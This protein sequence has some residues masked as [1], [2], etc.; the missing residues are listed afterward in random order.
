QVL[1]ANDPLALELFEKYKQVQMPNLRLGPGD[2]DALLAYLEAQAA[3][4][5]KVGQ[6][7]AMAQAPG[8]AGP[9]HHEH[10]HAPEGEG[11]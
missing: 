11:K 3:A 1:A 4:Q 8:D 7:A 9:A 5:Q 6:K 10:H 2:L